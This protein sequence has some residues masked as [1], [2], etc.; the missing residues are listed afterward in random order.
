M[1][2]FKINERAYNAECFPEYLLEI[3]EIFRAREISETYP[4]MDNAS[5]KSVDE[6]FSTIETSST[7]I[8]SNDCREFYRHMES[9]LL[10]CIQECPG[11]HYWRCC[12]RE[13]YVCR[14]TLRTNDHRVVSQDLEHTNFGNG[15][16]ALTR[17]AIGQMKEQI[18]KEIATPSSGQA[19][20]MV[21]LDDH[22]LVV[23]PKQ[24]TLN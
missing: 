9:Y 12:K 20:L 21:S 5:S 18:S 15:S 8:T 19:S 13:Q 16:Q 10:D 14:E 3:F 22:V 2:N 11:H 4:V 6:R 17:R 7:H 23:L 24:S 1:V